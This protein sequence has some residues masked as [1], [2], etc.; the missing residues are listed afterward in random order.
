[1][2][3]DGVDTFVE[4]GPGNVLAGLIS[5]IDD[6]CKVLSVCSPDELGRAI[7]ALKSA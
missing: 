7:G 4:F 5:K 2:I 6:S 1:M 3:A